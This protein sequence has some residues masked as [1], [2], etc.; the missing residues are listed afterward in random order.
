MSVRA[1]ALTPPTGGMRTLIEEAGY[2]VLRQE[3]GY[4]APLIVTAK[5]DSQS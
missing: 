5:E 3:G 2:A 1:V 4:F